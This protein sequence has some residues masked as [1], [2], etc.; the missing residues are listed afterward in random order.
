MFAGLAECRLDVETWSMYAA[1]RS[2]FDCV[3]LQ[4]FA[5]LGSLTCAGLAWCLL[6]V[7]GW[8]VYAVM[9]SAPGILVGILRTFMHESPHFLAVT[10]ARL[11]CIRVLCACDCESSMCVDALLH[12][13]LHN[14]ACHILLTSI[15]SWR[16][17]VPS[18]L[19]L[20]ALSW[21]CVHAI[22]RK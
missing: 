7:V 20:W 13:P 19:F 6:D 11:S 21:A 3:V 9:C 1:I 12:Q 10:G 5:T 14:L 2:V 4:V 8:R 15:P 16:S 17:R 18:C 22:G